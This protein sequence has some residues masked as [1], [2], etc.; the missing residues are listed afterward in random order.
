MEAVPGGLY[1][2]PKRKWRIISSNGEP[3]LREAP[4]AV[5]TGEEMLVWGGGI[6]GDYF[7]DGAAFTP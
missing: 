6:G 4:T 1:D 3:S 5:W 2:V 7:N